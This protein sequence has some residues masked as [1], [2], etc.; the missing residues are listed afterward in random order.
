MLVPGSTGRS[1]CM[2]LNFERFCFNRTFGIYAIIF[3][4]IDDP[5]PL[6]SSVGE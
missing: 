3:W 6:L 4:H 5:W 1:R 2:R